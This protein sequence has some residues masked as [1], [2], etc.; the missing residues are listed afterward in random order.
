MFETFQ[1]VRRLYQRN[2]ADLYLCRD[3]RTQ[4]FVVIKQIHY[5]LYVNEA[6]PCRRESDETDDH[7]I[8]RAKHEAAVMFKL[9][10]AGPLDHV[11]GCDE[12]QWHDE[13]VLIRMPYYAGGDLLSLLERQPSHRLPEQQ[14][15]SLFF[16][17]VQG[18]QCLH[19]NG[20]GHRDLS[21]EN[22]LID[23]DN[24][25]KICDFGLS[26]GAA[27]SS[28]ECVGKRNYMAPE[29][30]AGVEYNPIQADVWSLGILLFIMLTGSPLFD[31][32]RI[33]DN[34]FRAVQRVGVGGVLRQWRLQDA[35]SQST[36][37]LMTDMLCTSPSDRLRSV[38]QVLERLV[39]SGVR[40]D[41]EV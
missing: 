24:K 31:V 9:S 18:V 13:S 20:I 29:V 25:L 22:V 38:D 17:I 36:V 28:K 35:I 5:A 16:Q 19:D 15:L 39:S 1:P 12:V 6:D 40:G 4:Q 10:E 2:G 21:L 27:A 7:A 26:V 14:A 33:S 41:L 32:A 23:D 8:E 37:Q 30:V 34:R 3:R 11:V